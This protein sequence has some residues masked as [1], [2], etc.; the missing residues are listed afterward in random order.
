M[1]HPC[2]TYRTRAVGNFA[3]AV[4][5]V[6]AVVVV[7]GQHL[8]LAQ[9]TDPNTDQS[10]D[11]NADQDVAEQN[12]ADQNVDSGQVLR[13][14]IETLENKI[15]TI[16]RE[17]EQARE[18]QLTGTQPTETQGLDFGVGSVTNR[19]DEVSALAVSA[20]LAARIEILERSIAALRAASQSGQ[21]GQDSSGL[22]G[23]GGGAEAP[24]VTVAETTAIRARLATLETQLAALTEGEVGEVRES[25]EEN[26]S[27]G[28]GESRGGELTGDLRLFVR[29]LSEVELLL[30]NLTG[31]IE[32]LSFRVNQM[33]RE[34]AEFSLAPPSEPIIE[35]SG[36]GG[37]GGG[38]G[39]VRTLG[40][41]SASDLQETTETFS[42][43]RTFESDS[44]SD[45]LIRVESETPEV[46]ATPRE[47]Y[48]RAFELLRRTEYAAAE[49]ELRRFL[50]H[51]PNDSLAA[52]A[53][54]W[55]GETLYV[56]KDYQA[57]ARVFAE[58]VDQDPEG[59]KTADNL[60]K[61]GLSFASLNETDK[62]CQ[63]LANLSLRYD[64]APETILRRA[65][66]EQRRI[67]CA[68]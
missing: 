25:G 10:T 37:A 12:V 9:S 27:G 4:I 46:A 39:E 56:R 32:E 19:A 8:A 20:K 63:I 14:R 58:G 23:G 53:R 41:V 3:F 49:A 68:P 66:V 44:E 43:L 42:S 52:N 62:A 6:A 22:L 31:R 45:S 50:E 35:T 48:D 24:A 33:E 11:Q 28:E 30:A 15:A 36:G 26:V 38:G 59:P 47:Q 5:L 60:L 54:Y 13:S 2:R 34:A 67:G 1:R 65:E 18:A 16:Q 51:W 17:A 7:G 64:D 55:L 57:A 61:L 40:T 29:R 21:S